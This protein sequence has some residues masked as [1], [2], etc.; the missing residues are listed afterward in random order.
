MARALLVLSMYE[1][2][3]ILCTRE[4]QNSIKDSVHRLLKNQ[5]A[6]MGLQEYFKVT[7]R[8]I[9]SYLGGFFIFKGMH[10]N[11]DEIKSTEGIDIAMVEE[12]HRVANTSWQALIPTVRNAGSEIW[13]NFN[14]DKE[15]DP[16]YERLVSGPPRDDTLLINTSYR[17]NPYFTDELRAEM[18]Y[19]RKVDPE[20]AAHVWDGA[21]RK[22]SKAEIFHGKWRV[23]RFEPQPDWDGP[24]QGADWGFSVDPTV[25]VRCWIHGRKLYI[26]RELYKVRVEL[27]DLPTFFDGMPLS[28]NYAIK[29]DNARPETISHMKS[30]GFKISAA[31]KFA[32]SV[33]EGIAFLRS[34]EEI[35]IHE[36]NV[37]A[38]QEAKFYRYKLDRLT[39]EPT[40]EI[41]DAHNHVW[42]AVRYALEK[43][44][45]RSKR[46]GRPSI[47]SL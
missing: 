34:F 27:G 11:I 39:E 42:D 2:L 26:E 14:P 1:P 18:E 12:A 16:T 7:D 23:D 35:V 19:D 24:Y 25:L 17:D 28:R 29:A 21:F 47:R 13:V 4:Y 38:I 6:N 3:G 15:D 45:Y 20:A 30:A 44:I 10:H 37:H 8:E 9:T 36:R 22:S 40:T 46:K 32:G 31:Q 33:E 41:I 5:I 43:M